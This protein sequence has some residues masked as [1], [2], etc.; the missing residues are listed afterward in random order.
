MNPRPNDVARDTAIVLTPPGPA[1]I[2]VVRLTGPGVVA[3]LAQHFSKA[4][5]PS[6]CVHGDLKDGPVILDDPIVILAEDGG[7]AEI[8]LHGGPWVVASTL[9]LL[10][11]SGFAIVET[12]R[13]TPL[14]LEHVD[15][16][17]PLQR[18]IL[19]HLHL[20]RTEQ[21]IRL[22]LAQNDA[23]EAL[24]R[25]TPTARTLARIGD[26]APMLFPPRIAI[27]GAPNVGKSTLANQLF[28]QERSITAD[29]PGTTRDWVG[30]I[31]N[32]DGLPVMLID[33][34]GLRQTDDAIERTAIARSGE[35]VRGSELV[36]EVIDA[37]APAPPA[38]PG[39]LRVMNK[40]D[41][42]HRKDPASALYTVA[43]TGEGIDALRAAIRARFDFQPINL[44]RPMVWTSRHRDL[45]RRARENPS[46]LQEIL[47]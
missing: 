36:V 39:A 34:P 2:A 35:M 20:A 27:V 13:A 4:V 46:T 24:L 1:A 21:G 22:L 19:S 12:N 5:A 18:E 40:S 26:L 29:L 9:E 37:S 16:E 43:T 6:R 14:D 32:L 25:E 7:A 11:R 8:H 47:G 31:A 45:L 3:F 44:T 15:G 33:T 41:R 23:W 30:A 38:W 10:R 17:S 42:A 28:A